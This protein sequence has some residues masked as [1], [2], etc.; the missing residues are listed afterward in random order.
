MANVKVPKPVEERLK[1][2]VPRYQK[3]LANAK[4]GSDNKERRVNEDNT[5]TLV[6]DMLNEV[7][8]FQKDSEI[9]QEYKIKRRFC[10]VAV[11][12]GDKIQYLVEVKALGIPLKDDHIEQAVNYAA[13]EEKTDWVVLT[14]GLRWLVFRV[15]L[16]GKVSH[17]QVCE[18]DF[19]KLKPRTET[20]QETLFLLCKGGVN[21]ALI[22]KLYERQQAVNKHKIAAALMMSDEVHKVIVRELKKLEPNAKPD[23]GEIAKF[24]EDQIIPRLIVDNEK[25][26]EAIA[27]IKRMQ[28]KSKK[29]K[30]RPPKIKNQSTRAVNE[31]TGQQEEE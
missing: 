4:E 12:L 7:F 15:L 27:K 17:E 14:N 9:T 20:D 18:F 13:R 6:I 2:Q 5:V 10:D 1:K 22:E 3:R 16:T 11:K 8:G 29:K 24:I 28:N 26:T 25:T 31:N 19:T 23:K 30:P 21:K